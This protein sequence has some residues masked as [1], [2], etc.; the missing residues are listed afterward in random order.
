[1]N[2]TRLYEV[3]SYFHTFENQS[4]IDCFIIIN[5]HWM[6]AIKK[7]TFTII[8]YPEF[9][10]CT[11][12]SVLSSTVRRF[13][14]Y[15]QPVAQIFAACSN[16]NLLIKYLCTIALSTG[17]NNAQITEYASTILVSYLTKLW[18]NIYIYIC[19]TI[20][21]IIRINLGRQYY[22]EYER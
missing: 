18:V 13:D 19:R 12:Y 20:K 7:T 10:K 16:P 8:D 5:I 9:M 21:W 17:N 14:F 6:Q 11:N 22:D 2:L 15:H 4:S 1:M 3:P